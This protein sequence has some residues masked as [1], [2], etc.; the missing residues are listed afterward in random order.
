MKLFSIAPTK[1]HIISFEP[2][3]SGVVRVRV[4][5][6]AQVNVYAL[7]ASGRERY[8]KG[9]ADLQPLAQSLRHYQHELGFGLA[10]IKWFLVIENPGPKTASGAYS[11][12]TLLSQ[13][14]PTGM[15]GGPTAMGGWG[16]GWGGGF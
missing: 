11:V 6:D 12:D 7:D 5:M 1:A 15:A 3:P 16:R 4:T 10:P 2:A 13:S 8:A 14:V 9:E